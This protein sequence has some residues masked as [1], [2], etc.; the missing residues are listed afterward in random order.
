MDIADA[1]REVRT[2]SRG[3]FIGQLVGGTVW[4]LSAALST[5]RSPAAG[6]VALLVGGVLIFPLTVLG[7][8]VVYGRVSLSASNPMGQLGAQIACTINLPLVGAATLY[9]LDWFYP[10]CLLAV[11]SHFV[12]F[13]FLYGMR[14]FAVMAAALVA[15][16]LVI[17]LYLPP[18]FALGGWIG[19]GV[20]LLF[21]FL[22]RAVVEKE[23]GQRRGASIVPGEATRSEMS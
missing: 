13:V 12:P 14:M 16:G 17:G 8:R 2:V 23:S 21:A 1:Q 6:I 7:L 19:A 22:G 3:G 9:R 11:G 18:S 20:L 5:W 4:L 15:S 10:A